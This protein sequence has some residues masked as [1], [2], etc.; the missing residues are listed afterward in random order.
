[1]FVNLIIAHKEQSNFAWKSVPTKAAAQFDWEA[2]Q[3]E[4]MP[5]A[6]CAPEILRIANLKWITPGRNSLAL[7]ATAKS[8]FRQASRSASMSLSS[9][10]SRILLW[11]SLR[12]QN[13]ISNTGLFYPHFCIF[14]VVPGACDHHGSPSR[15]LTPHVFGMG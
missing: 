14:I 10:T 7:V 2:T 6:D 9:R 11:H 3:L 13:F 1:M 15:L 4:D 8:C 12:L 5:V